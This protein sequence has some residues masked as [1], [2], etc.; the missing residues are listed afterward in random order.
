MKVNDDNLIN[1]IKKQNRIDA[2]NAEFFIKRKKCPVFS[3]IN[4]KK[5]FNWRYYHI[6]KNCAKREMKHATSV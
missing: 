5:C 4:V 1:T 6:A 2:V 3:Y